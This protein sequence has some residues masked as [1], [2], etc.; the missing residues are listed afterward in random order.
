MHWLFSFA[1][2]SHARLATGSVPE[3]RMTP[4]ASLLP[5]A[6]PHNTTT[7]TQ[8]SQHNSPSAS[9]KATPRAS[10]RCAS[11]SATS[12]RACPPLCSALTLRRRRGSRRGC[13]GVRCC[14][15]CYCCV[16]VLLCCAVLCLESRLAPTACFFSSAPLNASRPPLPSSPSPTTPHNA[17]QHNNTTTEGLPTAEFHGRAQGR[18]EALDDFCSGETAVRYICS[19]SIANAER[20]VRT[21]F[22]FPTEPFN[23]F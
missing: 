15:G 10:R 14:F 19:I 13:A 22:N 6:Y 17:T 21:L 3:E 1:V 18:G 7:T 23:V 16:M 5:H 9:L 2:L 8:Q 11:A 4:L 12:R 20:A